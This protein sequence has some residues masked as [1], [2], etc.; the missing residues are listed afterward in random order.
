MLKG[1][2]AGLTIGLRKLKFAGD[3]FMK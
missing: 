1:E 3:I 2:F